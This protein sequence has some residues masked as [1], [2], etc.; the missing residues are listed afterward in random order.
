MRL[1]LEAGLLGLPPDFPP[2]P[3]AYY[4]WKEALYQKQWVVYTKKPFQGVNKVVQY[5]AR[6]SHRVAITNHRLLHIDHQNVHF[7]YKDYADRALNK[8][9]ILSGTDFLKRFCLHILPA[10]FRKIRQFGFLANVCKAKDLASARR[11]IEGKHAQLLDRAKRKQ[12]AI[13][14]LF[15]QDLNRCPC[16]KKGQMHTID[17][18]LA[19]KDPPD[20]IHQMAF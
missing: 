17:V 20:Y 11:A 14:R 10:R 8:V 3:K 4:Q 13:M 19:N 5:L 6:Y 2:T 15:K 9:M 12:M 16:C 7:Q 1:S 18:W